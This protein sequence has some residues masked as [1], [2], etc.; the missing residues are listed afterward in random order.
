MKID[1]SELHKL[2]QDLE[3]RFKK[4][5]ETSF[6]WRISYYWKHIQYRTLLL[7]RLM[8][9]FKD[10]P[11]LHGFLEWQYNLASIHSGIEFLSPLGGGVIMPHFGTIKLNANSIGDSV[12]IFH[13]VTIGNDYA[14]GRPTI[15]NNV[16]IGAHS[17]V[18]GEITIGDNVI[19]GANSFVTSDVPSNCLVAGNP[20]KVIKS[21]SSDQIQEM[22]GY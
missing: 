14:T 7:Y 21:I 5:P 17:L 22:I 16:F 9:A 2:N 20:A 6:S 3:R 1:R 13:N 8:L 4:F 12:Y 15:G 18:L 10:V 11:L 19:I